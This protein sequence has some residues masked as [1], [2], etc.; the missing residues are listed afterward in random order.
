MSSITVSATA[1][2]CL[3]TSPL[4]LI[5]IRTSKQISLPLKQCDLPDQNGLVDLCKYIKYSVQFIRR[6][7]T[8][9]SASI[10]KE[11]YPKTIHDFFN[12]YSSFS[13]FS[14]LCLSDLPCCSS[15][16][17]SDV[18]FFHLSISDLGY[19]VRCRS[20]FCNSSSHSSLLAKMAASSLL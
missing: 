9:C 5:W 2:L 8:E 7:N 3:N 20:S 14:S 1:N 17:H 18:H 13:S 10:F 15:F 4:V 16:H 12:K 11:L 6:N 19:S